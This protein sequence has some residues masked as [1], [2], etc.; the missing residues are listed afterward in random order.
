ALDV[1]LIH[2]LSGIGKTH[3]A[4]EIVLQLVA[5]NNRVLVCG[6]SNVSVD[7]LVERLAAVR[8]LPLVRLGHPARLLPAAV[9]HSL[10]S[11]TKYSEQ[12]QLVNV[13]EADL[14]VLY[15][16]ETIAAGVPA[17]V[18]ALISPYGGQVRLL[19]MLLRAKYPDLEIGSV[20]GFQGREK[21]AA[22]LSFVR[23]NKQCGIGFLRDY[24]RNSVAITR[25]RRHLCIIADGKTVPA[26][27]PF[28]K[29]LFAHLR[30]A[31]V[32]RVP[33]LAD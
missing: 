1:A 28:L 31:A 25:A 22:I 6:P 14:A 23:S 16:D 24:R 30:R 2:G 20:D 15:V 9:A 21:E 12:A 3:T 18:I 33:T 8:G 10:N 13:G 17:K 11:H 26:H 7:N 5:R 19:K 27:D 32:I 4:V 29:A